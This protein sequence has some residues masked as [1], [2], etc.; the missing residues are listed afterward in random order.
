MQEM[1]RVK[2]VKPEGSG[3]ARE[4]HRVEALEVLAMIYWIT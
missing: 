2:E 4:L 3:E 1:R